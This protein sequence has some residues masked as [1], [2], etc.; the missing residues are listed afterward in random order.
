[1]ALDHDRYR[2]EWDP[3]TLR[4]VSEKSVYARIIRLH[5]GELLCCYQRGGQSRV[6]RSLDNGST[7]DGEVLVTDYRHGIAANPELRQLRDGRVLLCYNERPHSEGHPFSIMTVL[8]DDGGRTWGEAKRLFTAGLTKDDGC[9]EPV[10]LQYPD[11]EVQVFFANEKPY[12]ET[13]EQEIS[14]ISSK[15]PSKVWTVSRRDNARDGMSVPCLLNDGK[16]VA[17]AIE[18]SRWNDERGRMKPVVL[19]SSTRQ[20]WKEGRIDA[21]SK[22]REYALKNEL[23]PMTY[24]GAPYLVQMP[25]G[26]T[27][28]SSQLENA[29]GVQQMVVYLGNEQARDFT[30]GSKPFSMAG[31]AASMWNSLFVKE[32]NTV[33]AVSGTRIDGQSGIWIIDGK[34]TGQ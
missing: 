2:I 13:N 8:S 7:W 31:A 1:M 24:L 25:T 33:T 17:M 15:K 21:V 4:L 6:K 30:S 16:T 26:I 14:M 5:S 9:W 18:D 12:T 27:V 34:I 20:R 22:R 19:F 23:P 29:E 32:S 10:A 11:G 28:L 3:A